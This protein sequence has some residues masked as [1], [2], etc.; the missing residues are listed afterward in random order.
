[1]SVHSMDSEAESKPRIMVANVPEENRTLPAA[2]GN[3]PS[4]RLKANFRSSSCKSQSDL[5]KSAKS[6]ADISLLFS[7]WSSLF[8]ASPTSMSSNSG[9]KIHSLPAVRM[10]NN[11]SDG[12]RN[13]QTPVTLPW[14]APR[15]ALTEAS[16]CRASSSI[17]SAAFLRSS[18]DGCS[19][20]LRGG[21]SVAGGVVWAPS[22]LSSGR[23]VLRSLA[24]LAAPAAPGASRAPAMG[25]LAEAMRATRA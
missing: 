5:A 11:V 23:D 6:M 24:L 15:V 19:G 22:E 10:D 20:N 1:M 25:T 21:G 14:R 7:P 13:G 16:R 12:L 8:K 17:A 18:S 4:K 3:A 2:L 9:A